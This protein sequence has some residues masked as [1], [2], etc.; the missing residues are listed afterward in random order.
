MANCPKC[1]KHLKLTDWKQHCPYCGANIVVYD[2]Q[3][4]LMQEA[5]VAEVEYYHFQKKID[6]VKASFVGTKLAVARIFTSL[7]PAGAIFLPLINA[8]FS[9]PF[10]VYEGNIGMLDIVK[11]IN[12][13]TGDAIPAMLSDE[14]KT[15]GIFFVAAVGFFALSLVMTLL[16]FIL[17][18]LSCSPKGK[19]RNMIVDVI[20]LAFTVAA[21]LCFMQIPDNK[22]VTGSL[23][24]GTFLYILL[25]LV[26][27]GVDI[28][29]MK[30][31][32]PVHHKQCYV[33][34]IPIEEYFKLQEEGKS[35][36]E[37]RAIQYIRL[38]ELQDAEDARR[39]EEEALK[40]KEEAE[41]KEAE[42]A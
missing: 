22:Y 42:K 6:R 14:S 36:E 41:K 13:L 40:A 8:K 21:P 2:I 5:D 12:G 19:Q 4:R 1:N 28:A 17:N 10:E 25:Q 37:I 35:T 30:Q 18:T 23:A 33:G 24:V 38:Q 39:A 16:H 7:L 27:V 29:A 9:E 32:I 31:G 20:L 34:G 26:N 3:E 15:A 11:K